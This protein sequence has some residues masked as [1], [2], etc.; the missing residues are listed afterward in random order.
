M[1]TTGFVTPGAHPGLVNPDRAIA[2]ISV[3]QGG[4][5]RR[6][7]ARS[8]GLT[9]DQI[10]TRV[11]DG[12]WTRVG[13]FGYRTIEMTD[14]MD[15]V[16]A[17][18]AALPSAVVSHESAANL[19]RVPR[20][21]KG[22][23]TVLVHSRTTHDFPGVDV[24][25]CHD[26]ADAH[27]TE[28][29][30]L[31]TTTIARTVVDLAA[32]LSRGHLA[33]VTD[34]VLAAKMATV[35]ELQSVLDDVAR[36]GKP[37]VS[38]LRA[39]LE[40]RGPGPESGTAFERLGARVLLDGGLPMPEFEFSK[41]WDVEQRFDLAYPLHRLAVEW[42]SRRWHTQVGAFARDRER[43]RK[44]V[45]HGWRV[46]RFAWEDLTERPDHVVETVRHALEETA[47]PT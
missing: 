34:E 38:K 25:R 4:V 6:D 5:V 37:G 13:K 21:P 42:D 20:I 30:G 24:H 45:L 9:D 18:I 12:R 46:L 33:V 19:L 36:R 44:A 17:A 11:K 29:G 22:A 8:S 43:D 27:L 35:Q 3:R 23:A 2:Q 1:G 41:P 16:R 7:Q 15:R 39:V 10:D 28:V 31:P 14:P 32:V 40:T 47:P 26:L